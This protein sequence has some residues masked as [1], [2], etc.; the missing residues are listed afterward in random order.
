ML[1]KRQL[2]V[3]K[4][5]IRSFTETNQPVGSKTLMQELPIHVSSATIRNDMAALEEAGLITK[6]HSSSG[7]VPSTKGYRFYLDNLVE[8]AQAEPAEIAAIQQGFG[9]HFYK[10][11]EIVAQSARILSNLT[12]YTAI[13]LGPEVAQLK[14]TG[15]RMVPLG[16]HQV[17]AILV[18]S[19]GNVVNQ[20]F[21]L[22]G[23]VDSEEVEKA[24]RIVNDQL[25]GLPL[26]QVAQKLTTDVP[27]LLFQYM[28]SPDGFL[29]IFGSVLKQA[30]AERFYVGG[31]LNL[32]DYLD[33]SDVRRVKQIF[34]LFDDDTSDI[35][36]LIGP[37]SSKQDVQVHLGQEL[38]PDV[39][40]DLSV[41][42]ASYSVGD[43]GTGMIALLGPTQMPYSKMIGLLDAFREELAKRLTDYYSHFDQ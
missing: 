15:F 20:L 41:I 25:V 18:T 2:L 1:T 33:D 34:S 9:G 16:N 40:D 27:A 42:T 7:R 26:A 23:E 28:S 11:D 37:I 3:L 19:N 31:R 30:A 14:L 8:P 4:E 29:D 13:T 5:I 6:T 36:R 35:N 43:H 38:T 10:M 39:L 32:M 21:T 17:M 22:P 12:N 24:I